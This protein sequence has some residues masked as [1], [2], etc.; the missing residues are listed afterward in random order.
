M[1]VSGG[2]PLARATLVSAPA[3]LPVEAAS[4]GAFVA[5]SGPSFALLSQ[6]FVSDAA[7]G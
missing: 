1:I 7:A 6:P 4:D 3:A 5:F 2:I